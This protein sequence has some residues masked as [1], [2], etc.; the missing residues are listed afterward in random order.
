MIPSLY[1]LYYPEMK[2]S[3][4]S[5]YEE[6]SRHT[7]QQSSPITSDDPIAS[8]APNTKWTSGI[9]LQHD[10][11]TQDQASYQL[12]H[13]ETIDTFVFKMLCHI[14]TD[15]MPGRYDDDD[16]DAS[17]SPSQLARSHWERVR[18]D[19]MLNRI[20]PLNFGNMSKIVSQNKM[21]ILRNLD[22]ILRTTL[23]IETHKYQREIVVKHIVF[24]IVQQTG[25]R[26]KKFFKIF[27]ESNQ[28]S[29]H[30][31]D[32]LCITPEDLNTICTIYLT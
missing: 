10:S 14:N 15:H 12:L 26:A 21:L 9:L 25:S 24:E 16:K 13:T 8:K 2:A 19:F 30:L 32:L 6:N 11:T 29:Q 20:V 7:K 3:I 22:K 1:H 31:M 5:Q 27:A 17:L 23:R 18:R 28:A 4:K